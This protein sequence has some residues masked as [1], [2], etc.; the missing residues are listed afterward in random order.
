MDFKPIA[1][2][3]SVGVFA[4]VVWVYRSRAE[5]AE[6]YDAGSYQELTGRIRSGLSERTTRCELEGAS[7]EALSVDR[8]GEEPRDLGALPFGALLT[9]PDSELSM[10]TTWRLLDQRA[11]RGLGAMSEPEQNLVLFNQLEGEVMNGGFHQYFANSSGDCSALARRAARAIGGEVTRIVEA[12]FKVFPREP[13]EDRAT[14]N[15]QMAAL[16]S[17]WDAWSEIDNEFYQLRT[18]ELVARYIRA[19]AERIVCPPQTLPVGNS[20]GSA[21]LTRRTAN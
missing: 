19:H 8:A 5:R 7:P 17:E 4:A 20:A 9:K 3:V 10:E 11:I 18:D 15:A 14:R 16:P 13:A 6:L 21:G 2:V 1:A 12:A